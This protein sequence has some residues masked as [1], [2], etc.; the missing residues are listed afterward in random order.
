MSV[1]KEMERKLGEA[2]S[3]TRLVVNDDSHRHQGHAGWRPGGETHYSVEIV[4]AAFEGKSRVDR[5]RMVYAILADELAGGV[6]ALTLRTLTLG[7]DA[8][9]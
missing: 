3:P 8:S 4:S 1:A 7:E 5:Q 6:H 9:P 2:L